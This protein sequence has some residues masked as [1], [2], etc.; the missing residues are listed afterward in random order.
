METP[1]E[2]VIRRS[3][4]LPISLLLLLTAVL[5]VVTIVQ[6]QPV[7]KTV[8]LGAMLL[9]LALLCAEVWMRRIRVTPDSVTARKLGRS[10]TLRFA[11]LTAFESVVVRRRYYLSLSTEDDFLIISNAYAGFSELLELLLQL[12]P[13][14]VV[15]E[16][17]E[18]LAKEPL[19]RPTDM[20]SSWIGV[21]VLLAILYLQFS[22]KS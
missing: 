16:E 22:G 19:R 3:L 8:I 14:Q 21:L 17:V 18:R 4:Q 15:S 12:T 9:P 13:P 5:L 7:G 11:D 6:G 1:R 20:L 2:F 10:K